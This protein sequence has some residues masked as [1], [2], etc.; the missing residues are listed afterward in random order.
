MLLNIAAVQSYRI[1]WT[2][3][4]AQ[5]ARD[6]PFS[7]ICWAALEPIRRQVLS[8]MDDKNGVASVVGANFS[9][10]FIAG[11]FAAAA[12]C[13]LDVAKTRRQIEKDPSRATSMTTVQTLREIWSEDAIFTFS[14]EAVAAVGRDRAA[15]S[16]VAR[17]FFVESKPARL[18]QETLS[19]IYGF[20]RALTV[21]ELCFNLHQLFFMTK[22]AM[23]RFLKKRPIFMDDYLV[24][25]CSWKAPSPDLLCS[26]QFMKL[27]VRLEFVPDD[28]RTPAFASGFLGLIGEVTDVGMFSSPAYPGYFLRG[29]VRMDLLRPFFGR[30][31]AQ[32]E[33]GN[34]FGF[35]YVTRDS[36]RFATNVDAWGII[37]AVV[38]IRYCR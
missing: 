9:A 35:A 8:M 25:V 3:L 15:T 20:V 19:N 7:A 31:P 26:L 5:I 1:L 2:G 32:D 17:F 37:M 27:W 21:I 13:P 14:T 34:E 6:V 4:G 18:I 29:F 38:Q 36:P 22:E 33:H 11:S 30:R 16:L 23:Q 10:G 24:N 12:T 28:L